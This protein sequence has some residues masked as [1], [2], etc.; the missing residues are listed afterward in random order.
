MIWYR[1][2][3]RIGSDVAFRWNPGTYIDF[4][5]QT[6]SNLTGCICVCVCV[7]ACMCVCVFVCVCGVRECMCV[8][9]RAC[10]CVCVCVTVGFE[11]ST[12]STN[13]VKLCIH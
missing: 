9:V 8:C 5:C 7:R 12:K 1:S 2:T 11:V 10:V 6:Y 4:D 13:A 3:I